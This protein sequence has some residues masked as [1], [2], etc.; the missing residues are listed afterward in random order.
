MSKRVL[1]IGIDGGTWT[2]LKP[3]MEQGY[4]PFLNSLVDT[5]VSGILESTIPAITP[6]AWGSFQTGMNP[7]EN[8]VHDFF[9]WNKE[10]K[11]AKLVNSQNLSE[12]I[13]DIASRHSK[14]VGVV[15]VPMTYPPKE[16]NGYMITGLLTPSIESEFTF[17]PQLKAQLLQAIPDYEILNL[18]RADSSKYEVQFTERIEQMT[19]DLSNRRK[20]AEFILAK[21]SLDLFMVHF[22]ATDV[23]QHQF[24][25]HLTKEHPQCEPQKQQYLFERFYGHLDRQIH[26]IYESFWKPSGRSELTLIVSDHGFQDNKMVINLGIWLKQKGFLKTKFLNANNSFLSRIINRACNTLVSSSSSRSNK[27]DLYNWSKTRAYARAGNSEAFIYLLEEENKKR[28]VTEKQVIKEL[29]NLKD[30]V[31]NRVVNNVY[32]KHDVFHGRNIEIMPDLVVE[33]VDGYSF[34]GTYRQEAEFFHNVK[35]PEDVHVGKHHKDGIFVIH[36][37]EIIIKDGIHAKI[38]DIA[39]TILYAMSLPVRKDIDGSIL[40][41]IFSESFL[42]THSQSFYEPDR[43]TGQN[44]TTGSED[45]QSIENRL[46]DLGYL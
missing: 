4:M 21:E 15:N 12:T 33:P 11:K 40:R 8:G 24:W 20:A 23:I 34:H 35:Y 27:K 28:S 41:Q 42:K 22:Q 9:Q 18:I 19:R 16:I 46:K 30:P 1:I 44:E 13:W 2:V 3:A 38:E 10:E 36:G 39:P 25:C 29:L 31:G 26:E 32:R 43:A 6:P 7:G 14:R 37:E 17:P 5:G 45:Q